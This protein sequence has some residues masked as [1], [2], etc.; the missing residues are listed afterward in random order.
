MWTWRRTLPQTAP[1]GEAT[2][3]R[4]VRDIRGVW[5]LTKGEVFSHGDLHHLE[6]FCVLVLLQEEPRSALQ[7]AQCQHDRDDDGLVPPHGVLQ[8]RERSDYHH[9][10][11]RAVQREGR[12]NRSAGE[13]LVRRRNNP[14]NDRLWGVQR[15]PD[16]LRMER[17]HRESKLASDY[18]H[19]LRQH[20]NIRLALPWRRYRGVASDLPVG[21][22]SDHAHDGPQ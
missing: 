15:P 4:M 8:S 12:N 2:R 18:L 1:P 13:G 19:D 7:E 14:Q 17:L 21:C 22:P 3:Q 5:D 6:L 9:R 10:G 11:G 20:H 16:H